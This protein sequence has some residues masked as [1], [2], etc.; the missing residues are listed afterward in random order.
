MGKSKRERL[1][2]VTCSKIDAAGKYNPNASISA[3]Y[4][5]MFIC[6]NPEDDAYYIVADD[7]N[8]GKVC[9]VIA[10]NKKLSDALNKYV[11]RTVAYNLFN[12]DN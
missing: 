8:W 4:K 2:S 9:F 11:P 7:K 6:C 12:G 10:P 3:N 1:I 5:K